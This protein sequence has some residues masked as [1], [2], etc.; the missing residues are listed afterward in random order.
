MSRIENRD[1]IVPLL[2]ARAILALL[3]DLL[4]SPDV[5]SV[6]F[7]PRTVHRLCDDV[8]RQA[9]AIQ[10]FAGFKGD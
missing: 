10:K 6:T 1:F 3:N 9:S 8:I 4:D 7:D 2:R 5:D